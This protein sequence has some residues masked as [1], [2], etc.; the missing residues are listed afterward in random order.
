MKVEAAG[1]G[2][3][4]KETPDRQQDRPIRLRLWRNTGRGVA[5]PREQAVWNGEWLA[6]VMDLLGLRAVG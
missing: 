4:S 6:F 3:C 2:I 5:D 1:P